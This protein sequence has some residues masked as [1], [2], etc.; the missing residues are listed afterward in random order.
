ME[1]KRTGRNL[2]DSQISGLDTVWM[3]VLI[4]VC[5]YRGI[6][7]GRDDNEKKMSLILDMLT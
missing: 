2:Y 4:K 6:D 3:N 7:V 5:V 1:N